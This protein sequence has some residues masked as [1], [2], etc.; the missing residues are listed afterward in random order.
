MKYKR[1]LS[2]S[3]RL[4]F[5]ALLD[6]NFYP[7]LH[8]LTGLSRR[9]Q[10]EHS[11][12]ETGKQVQL[13]SLA[14]HACS[15]LVEIGAESDRE[16]NQV[17]STAIAHAARARKNALT[18]LN[19]DGSITSQ[20]GLTHARL[21]KLWPDDLIRLAIKDEQ[22]GIPKEHR[23]LC[24]FG[25]ILHLIDASLCALQ[26]RPSAAVEPAMRAA[27]CFSA[28]LSLG[29][30]N[31]LGDEHPS[32]NGGRAKRERSERVAEYACSLVA[33]KTFRSRAEAVRQIKQQ[34]IDFAASNE[35]WRMSPNQAD[36]TIGGWLAAKG[37]PSSAS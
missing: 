28:A 4:T 19:R 14:E 30:L 9:V 27:Y 2:F 31:I 17:V 24:L 32:V 6:G 35:N 12:L 1:I 22:L 36:T 16:I 7:P 21:L 11:N 33:G 34:V 5:E 23:S 20:P 15:H 18:L 3:P 26:S 37:L 13:F 8:R 29:G 25:I 10:V